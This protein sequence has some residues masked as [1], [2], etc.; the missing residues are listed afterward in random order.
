[1]T[2]EIDHLM[3]N[4]TLRIP[5]C[6]RTRKAKRRTSYKEPFTANQTDMTWRPF[7]EELDGHAAKGILQT[8]MTDMTRRPILQWSNGH[9]AKIILQWSWRT[10]C[11]NRSRDQCQEQ[12]RGRASSIFKTKNS[13][14]LLLKALKMAATYYI[15]FSPTMR[16][17]IGVAE[18][19]VARFAPCA[20]PPHAVLRCP[21]CLR[22]L[23]CIAHCLHCS[24]PAACCAGRT[25]L[26]QLASSALCDSTWARDLRK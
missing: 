9:D 17:T 5:I 16:S 21:A 18:L 11:N 19:G 22:S 13:Q 8:T 4:A 3:Q 15:V 25:L 26:C 14:G 24:L 2:W 6:Q 23:R 10:W 7:S 1:M 12:Q 20:V